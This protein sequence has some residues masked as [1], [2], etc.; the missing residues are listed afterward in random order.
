MGCAVGMFKK[1]ESYLMQHS[2]T[3][4]LVPNSG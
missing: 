1:L 3:G 2:G 4:K